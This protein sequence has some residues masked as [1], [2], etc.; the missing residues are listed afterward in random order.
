MPPPSY[1]HRH[2]LLSNVLDAQVA[3][4]IADHFA[5]ASEDNERGCKLDALL[6][7]GWAASGLKGKQADRDGELSCLVR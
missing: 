1:P 6:L 5:V 3:Q 2:L 7:A 4:P